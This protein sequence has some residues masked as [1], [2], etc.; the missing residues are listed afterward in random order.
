MSA[1]KRSQETADPDYA[2]AGE[3]QVKRQ[4]L[5]EQDAKE[6]VSR[7][8]Q[9]I[10]RNEFEKEINLKES[11]LQNI[12]KKL[13]NAL[14]QMDRLR[15]CIVASYYGQK[16]SSS[17]SN[18]AAASLNAP[19]PSIHPAAKKY[20]GK[21]PKGQAAA[22]PD[23]SLQVSSLT[24]ESH[25][26]LRQKQEDQ[27]GRTEPLS[28]AQRTLPPAAALTNGGLSLPSS[29]QFSE[30]H[31]RFKIK[32]KIIVGNVSKYIPVDSRE[33]SDMSSHKWMVYVR[34][35]K[36]DADISGFVRKVWFFL[37]HS[38]KP[39]DLVE[40][41]SPPFHLTRRGW[42]EFP[43]R[44]QLHFV[45]PRNKKLDI[46]HHL[47]LDKTF[48]GLQTLGAE[49]V[50]E[51]EIHPESS[52]SVHNSSAFSTQAVPSLA[53]AR[54]QSP[55]P[56]PPV[57]TV[58]SSQSTEN[59]IISGENIT[60]PHTAEP[61]YVVS[62]GLPAKPAQLEE[63]ERD[64][65]SIKTE[66]S[67]NAFAPI[68]KEVVQEEEAKSD[69]EAHGKSS[70]IEEYHMTIAHEQFLPL[71]K[72]VKE[73]A[74]QDV[75]VCADEEHK[76][77][78]IPPVFKIEPM[79]FA[80]TNSIVKQEESLNCEPKEELMDTSTSQLKSPSEFFHVNPYSSSSDKVSKEPPLIS[81]APSLPPPTHV[82]HS[83]LP[84]NSI[85]NNA[86]TSLPLSVKP[87]VNQPMKLTV[88]K[89]PS[90]FRSPV[91]LTPG[92]A[93]V[94]KTTSAE[95]SSSLRCVTTTCTT[96]VTT[97]GVTNTRSIPMSLSSSLQPTVVAK[98]TVDTVSKLPFT[99][100]QQQQ[101]RTTAP[102]M[103][104]IRPNPNLPIRVVQ[105][106]S[107]PKTASNGEASTLV[108]TSQPLVV[109]KISAPE[110]SHNTPISQV[111]KSVSVGGSAQPVV[112]GPPA[113]TPSQLHIAKPKSSRQVSLLTGLVVNNQPSTPQQ[114]SPSTSHIGNRN[115]ALHPSSDFTNSYIS[116]NAR[117][118]QTT[119]MVV[120]DPSVMSSSAQTHTQGGRTLIKVL[121]KAPSSL[122]TSQPHAPVKI[123][124]I[125]K[126]IQHG[127]VQ[128]LQTHSH[129]SLVEANSA[130]ATSGI[131]EVKS[132]TD[133]FNPATNSSSPQVMLS[134]PNNTAMPLTQELEAT[135]F[136]K[137]SAVGITKH[138]KGYRSAMNAQGMRKNLSQEDRLKGQY[139]V[140]RAF[141]ENPE[142]YQKKSKKI[143][144]ATNDT[145][146]GE[147][148]EI[149]KLQLED[150]PTMR[151]M[152]K[153]AVL[154]HPLIQHDVN[155]ITHPYCANSME[156]WD[157][158][159]IG[160]QR[161]AEW[162]RAS[163][164]LKYLKI[165]LD[166]QSEFKK[167]NLMSTRQLV[168]WCRLRAFSPVLPE[169]LP[170][171]KK[172][173]NLDTDGQET[174]EP[175]DCLP[176]SQGAMFVYDQ[177]RKRGIRLQPES[178]DSGVMGCL[179]AELIYKLMVEFCSDVL[180]E[181]LAVCENPSSGEL[182]GQDVHRGLTSL[183][184]AAFCCNKFLGKKDEQEVEF[185][186]PR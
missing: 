29:V 1:Q 4:R 102:K 148:E 150:Y 35:P 149:P 86:Q 52:G 96:T 95:T 171:P 65:L 123:I 156:E 27:D 177:L 124:S 58:P 122:T 136:P 152:V 61:Q 13:N 89:D 130:G 54:S 22:K 179:S 103:V 113:V 117:Q 47:K 84:S 51:V 62:A 137:M 138:G 24:T 88:I 181:T 70:G 121:N 164:T 128:T 43:V 63:R 176:L 28:D 77:E 165:C 94:V 92:N 20:L 23:A 57:Q 79:R 55:S 41:S 10:V 131:M 100:I 59:R 30:R 73:E 184:E 98:K 44:V 72:T 53:A 116:P 141:K 153:A 67:S 90:K 106:K 118:L 26:R 93:T 146:E 133:L 37:H 16:H 120:S 87:G 42:G 178:L 180:R 80:Y 173:E 110:A 97:A 162:L 45:D 186:V 31:S 48:T 144:L 91:G 160:K 85:A 101:E 139:E 157:S 145:L 36:T 170:C 81:S 8:I 49:T 182:S 132:V 38:Y 19:P 155:K 6:T 99:L 147:E 64:V 5:L 185:A 12:D 115:V 3:Q 50:V 82:I 154:L 34:G 46:I 174:T 18:S 127:N 74:D 17:S 111:Y 151:S 158:W 39:N 108:S 119:Q 60:E 107:S 183:P 25:E 7:K 109:Q 75:D 15:A 125:P 167:E 166:D 104:V 163:F 112:I 142:L 129:Q 134:F 168:D 78:T 114:V 143:V 71:L 56:T 21:A 11:E 2:D 9:N 83:N 161:A 159:P 172:E 40:V 76:G 169:T 135:H 140:L 68:K 32:K 66:S 105:R 33:A 14:L 175:D 126:N 69:S